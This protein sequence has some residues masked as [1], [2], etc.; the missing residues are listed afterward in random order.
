M[1][2]EKDGQVTKGLVGCN[3]SLCHPVYI[4]NKTAHRSIV[5]VSFLL[6]Y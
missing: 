2:V 6:G 3:G 5:N 1:A 4:I